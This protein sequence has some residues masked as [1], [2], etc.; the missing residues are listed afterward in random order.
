[1]KPEIERERDSDTVSIFKLYHHVSVCLQS[2]ILTPRAL[3]KLRKAFR[4][5]NIILHR[6]EYFDILLTL[7]SV[8]VQ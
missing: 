5:H 1:M 2:A 4:S 7:L 6:L 8:P 3:Y